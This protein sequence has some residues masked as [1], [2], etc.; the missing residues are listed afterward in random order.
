M[1]MLKV[2]GKKPTGDRLDRIR[3]T[4]G[5]RDAAFQNESY[6]PMMAEDGSYLRVLR[7]M[8]DRS[9]PKNH[10]EEYPPLY[11]IC[12]RLLQ[13]IWI[14][15]GSVIPLIYWFPETKGFW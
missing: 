14:C 11:P 3:Q 5:Y 4:A 12:S 15:I 1:G 7:T 9:I 2:F 13:M 6:T 10:R 8:F